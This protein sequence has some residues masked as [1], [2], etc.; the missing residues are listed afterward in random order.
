[1]KK[2]CLTLLCAMTILSGCE[3]GNAP[4]AQAPKSN[5]SYVS[6]GQEAI[7]LPSGQKIGFDG[8]ILK[9][10]IDENKNGKYQRHVIELPAELMSVEGTFFSSLAKAGYQRK[11]N[12]EANG[13]QI[14]SYSKKGAPL[15]RASF[16]NLN[17]TEA[18]AAPQTR[19]VLSWKV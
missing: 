13:F 9:S 7:E 10:Y 12:S 2:Y 15:I 17:N 19:L 3:E 1:M 6:T 4:Q 18:K 14:Y 5:A 11:N 8:K 16:K